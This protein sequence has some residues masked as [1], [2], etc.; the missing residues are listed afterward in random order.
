MCGTFM[1]VS[2]GRVYP[3]WS[4]PLPDGAA[5][6]LLT[7]GLAEARRR[8]GEQFGEERVHR[9]LTEAAALPAGAGDAV[10]ARLDA[11]LRPAIP[12]DDI[13]ILG[14]RPRQA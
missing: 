4:H 8:D 5:V 13:T 9:A 2:S 10:L 12:D 6:Y 11:W 1:G 7:D 3:S 14:V